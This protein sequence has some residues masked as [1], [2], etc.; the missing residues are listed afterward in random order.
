VKFGAG[1]RCGGSTSRLFSEPGSQPV[2]LVGAPE[3]VT[4]KDTCRER[5]CGLAVW[6]EFRLRFAG[7]YISARDKCLDRAVGGMGERPT[8]VKVGL[9]ERRSDSFN[10]ATT[11]R[12]NLE[13][14]TG[15]RWSNPL[16]RRPSL[17]SRSVS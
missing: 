8:S 10:A 6:V 9:A 14:E 11:S 4:G 16:G 15:R 7:P 3:D 17:A 13:R 12:A 2:A 1:Q 5:P